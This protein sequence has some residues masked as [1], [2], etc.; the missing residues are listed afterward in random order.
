MAE[1]HLFFVYKGRAYTGDRVEIDADQHT[2]VIYNGCTTMDPWFV[3]GRIIELNPD[4]SGMIHDGY[5]T[6]SENEKSDW[7]IRSREVTLSKG[8]SIK[9]KNVSFYFMHLPILWLPYFASDLKYTHK[10]PFKYRFR[11][12]GKLGPR[13]GL[14][15]ELFRTKNFKTELLFDILIKRG[16]GGGIATSYESPDDKEKLVTYNYIAHDLR[17]KEEHQWLRYRFQGKYSNL[18]FHDQVRLQLTYDKLS[19]LDMRGDYVN[20]VLDAGR[21][22]PAQA[23]FTHRNDHWV[24]SLN[25]KIRLNTFQTVKKEIPLFDFNAKPILLGSSGIILNNRFNAGYLDYQYANQ[26][27]NVRDFHSSRIELSQLLY[28]NFLFGHISMTPYAGY[29]VISYNN[30]PQNDSKLLVVGKFGIETHSRF[31][32]PLQSGSVAVEPYVK[33]EYLTTPTVQPHEHYLFDM[34]DGWHRLNSVRFGLR[35]FLMHRETN[36]F[37]DQY[38]VDLYARAFFDTPTMARTIPRIYAEA[39]WKPTSLTRYST[40]IAWDVQRKNLDHINLKADITLTEYAAFS[41]EYRHRNAFSWR[42][43]DLQNFI[44]DSFRPEWELRNSD[45]SDRRDTIL[46]HIFCR[47]TPSLALD[48]QTQHGFHRRGERHYNVY[49]LDVITL[50]RGAV[51]LKLSLQYRGKEFR[52]SIEC[53]FGVD[54]PRQGAFHRFGQGNYSN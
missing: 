43:V 3:G 12:G 52:R 1:G 4:G 22:E 25:T 24:S 32:R 8:S 48:F 13:V 33:Y 16:L 10:A 21:I 14:S 28:R 34:E 39:A 54:K 5:M 7:T 23:L 26:T 31:V 6:T 15:Y 46:A 29:S 37:L 27:P 2:V 9:A 40:N 18:Y 17:S 20:P 51:T 35:N 45:M 19:D 41:V 11:W 36:G 50:I 38:S 44:I 53:S 42:K 47:L 49:Q 30:S